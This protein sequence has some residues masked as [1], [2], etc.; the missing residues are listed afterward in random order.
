MR[1][2]SDNTSTTCPEILEALQAANRGLAAPYGEDEWT[3]RLDGALSAFF[4]TEVRAFAVLTGTAANALALATLSPPYGA[5]FAHDEAH[6][7][8]DEC[9]APGFFSGG[10]QLALLPG[11][12]GR[13]SPETL[14]VA[15]S[16]PV[17]L[18]RVQPAAL[19]LTQ[20]TELGTTYRPDEIARLAALAHERGLRVHMDGARLANALVFLGCHPG[21]IT[22]RAG[23]EVLSFGATKNG[24]L[25]AEAVVFFDRSLVRDFE[26]RRKR[27]GHLLS[28]SRYV[29]AQ[30][31]A[32]V[33]SGVWK[34]NAERTNAQARRIGQ[35]AGAALLHPVEANE[36]F[37]S[38][39]VPRRRAL[40]EAG[41]EFY[42]LGAESAGA[43][44]FVVSWDQPA[45][46]VTA[47]CEALVTARAG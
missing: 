8:N 10:A 41:F 46:D 9:G 3:V 5:I 35:A 34:R 23:V 19:S 32:Y 22:W 20:A 47:L 24:A 28:K 11:E 14:G 27:A 40:R 43:A 16:R 21:D 13:L 42:D 37:V 25:G 12:H 7:A 17:D 31:L 44:R 26:L 38:L 39:G 18:H 33:E 4:G 1:F 2:L 6:I 15:L 30:L 29:A 36:V 45:A